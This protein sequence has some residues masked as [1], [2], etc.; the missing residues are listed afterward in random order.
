MTSRPFRFSLCAL[1]LLLA[2]G[3]LPLLG[4]AAARSAP[5]SAAALVPP[6]PGRTLVD[7]LRGEIR[8]DDPT[9][10]EHALM[11]VV[12]LVNC[13]DYCVLQLMSFPGK[14]LRIHNDADFGS[15]I[16]VSAL[17]P[18]LV[19][20]YQVGPT[21]GLRLLS[22]AGLL[23]IGDETSLEHLLTASMLVS[24][25]HVRRTTHRYI[26]DFFVARYPTLRK[27]V[28]N[29]GTL[30]R[31]AIHAARREAK[32]EEQLSARGSAPPR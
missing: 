2:Y 19:W 24:S 20:A 21:E 14:T 3:G 31:A 13:R 15:V 5:A 6:T 1:I 16:D 25:P 12:T 18:D 11:D 26:T 28:M 7:Y 29:T 27:Q 32:H 8:S 17:A 22:L 23:Y 30:S 9:R 4:A 10:R